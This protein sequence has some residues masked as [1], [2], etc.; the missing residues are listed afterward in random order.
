MSPRSRSSRRTSTC[1]SRSGAAARLQP[2]RARALP[3]RWRGRRGTAGRAADEDRPRRG[4][5]AFLAQV[6]EVTLGS[7]PVHAVSAR[8]GEGSTNC[9]PGC[10]RTAPRCSSFVGR[11]QVDDR[12][13]ARRR[14]AALHPGGARGRSDGPALDTHRE[15]ILVPTAASSST[16][17]G[18]ASYSSGTQTSSRRSATSRRSHGAAASATATTTRSPAA[19]FAKRWPRGA[20]TGA[21]AELP[22]A[23][24]GTGGDRGPAQPPTATGTRPRIQDSGTREQ[25]EEETLNTPRVREDAVDFVLADPSTASRG[26]AAAGGRPAGPGPPFAWRDGAWALTFARP[27]ADRWST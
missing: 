5:A 14:G 1:R 18:S 27:E 15:L 20:V 3:S 13:L 7:V 25:T 21:L 17:R 19:R 23:A 12:Q 26:G 9:A 4:R 24:A 2:A 10:S 6:E 16:R 11:R 8:T 22:E